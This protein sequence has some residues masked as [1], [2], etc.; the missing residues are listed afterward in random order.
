M[1][2]T[3]LDFPN[4]C[5]HIDFRKVAQTATAMN[6]VMKRL[7]VSR[8]EYFCTIA[9]ISNALAGLD[10]DSELSMEVRGFL[11]RR[12]EESAKA[13]RAGLPPYPA[14]RNNKNG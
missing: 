3:E 11:A 2:P 12:F 4:D 6:E 14:N 7:G 10:G 5:P 9:M 8:R 1:K 13:L